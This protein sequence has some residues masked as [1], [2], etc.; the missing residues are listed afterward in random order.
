MSTY[1][2]HKASL[3]TDPAT[4]FWLKRAMKQLETRDPLDAYRDAQALAE[5]FRIRLDE[6]LT[7][8]KREG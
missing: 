3:L 2:K 1:A 6:V 8:L 4:S 7:K 5:L